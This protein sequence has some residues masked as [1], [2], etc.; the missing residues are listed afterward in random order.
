MRISY[1]TAYYDAANRPTTRADYG[2]NGGSS[3]LSSPTRSDT[4]LVTSYT[5][6]PAGWVD[7]INDPKGLVTAKA[8]DAM[9]RVTYQIEAYT[10]TTPPDSS[11]LP[12]VGASSNRIIAYAYDGLSHIVTLTAEMPSGTNSQTTQYV[13]G[14]TTSSGSTIDSSDLLATVEYPDKTSGSASTNSSEEQSFT[15]NA[16]GQQ[17]TFTD[18][19][20]SVHT[21]SYDVLGR[22]ISDAVTLGSGV[23]GTVQL[24]TVAF[25]T[26][27][28]PYLFSSYSAPSSGTLVNQ[29]ERVYNGLNQ[30]T[31]EYQAHNSSGVNTSTSPQI[32]YSYNTNFDT[33]SSGENNSRLNSMTYPNGRILDYVYN[34]GLDASITR[35][36][37]LADD[38]TG[39]HLEDYLYLGLGTIVER[40]HAETGFN[41]SYIQQSGDTYYNSDGGDQYTGLDRFG[42]VI[43]QFWLPV[44]TAT[45][46]QKLQRFQYAYDRDGDALYKNHLRKSSGNQ[47]PS[48]LSELYHSNSAASDDNASAYDN[49]NR[50]INYTREPSPHRATT[51]PVWTPWQAQIPLMQ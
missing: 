33:M 25:D 28:R 3:T 4:V 39:T 34:S 24:Q 14:V 30:L 35:V 48:S 6:N 8:Y 11:S 45:N 38:I 43:D 49:L 47:V 36:S 37:A 9:G 12:T 29:V 26:G 22:R 17:L 42:R 20:G 50:L 18:Q 21:Y 32:Q 16:V 1:S 15:Y 2:T 41:L 13:Y 7:R 5:Y 44:P 10:P 23:D 46:S 27:G 40:D 51:A 19:N 31:N